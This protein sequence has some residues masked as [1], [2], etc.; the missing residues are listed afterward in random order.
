VALTAGRTERDTGRAMPR[1]NVEV[2]RAIY[3]AFADREIDAA[4]AN[5]VDSG[6]ELR[7]PAIYPEGAQTFRG[8]AGIE[9]WLRMTEDTWGEWRFEVQR[10]IDAESTVVGLARIVAEGGVSHARVQRDVAHLWSLRHGRATSVDVYLDR[11]EALEAAG[12]RD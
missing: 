10:L 3:A 2:V 6:F 7:T 1:E 9:R 12:L 4:F 11:A 5:L 8:R